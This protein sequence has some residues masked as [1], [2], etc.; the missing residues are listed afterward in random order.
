MMRFVILA[1]ALLGAVACGGD[2]SHGDPACAFDETA[3][4]PYN[5]IFVLQRESDGPTAILHAS[6]PTGEWQ[7]KGER[8]E[9]EWVSPEGT[10]VQE[11]SGGVV[12]PDA[13]PGRV[14]VRIDVIA[15]GDAE[16]ADL[17]IIRRHPEDHR[18]L[19]VEGESPLSRDPTRFRLEIG[20]EY[21]LHLRAAWP[22]GEAEFFFLVRVA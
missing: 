20:A 19:G 3:C 14:A 17:R 6:S 22:E 11:E 2:E 4:V 5:L 12:L 10:R 8:G 7:Q 1:L 15:D 18:S 13:E 16:R 9:M 21:I